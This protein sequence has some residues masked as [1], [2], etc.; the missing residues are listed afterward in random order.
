MNPCRIIE[1]NR[2]TSCGDLCFEHVQTVQTVTTAPA[3]RSNNTKLVTHEQCAGLAVFAPGGKN[4]SFRRKHVRRNGPVSYH[5]G[6]SIDMM[7]DMDSGRINTKHITTTSPTIV[8]E[9]H[10]PLISTLPASNGMNPDA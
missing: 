2:W 10:A 1:C 9:Y 5:T 7:R 4:R 6:F 8:P 3:R